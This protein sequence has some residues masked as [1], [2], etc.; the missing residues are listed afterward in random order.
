VGL[1]P[2]GKRD[3]LDWCIGI[4][5]NDLQ[6]ASAILMRNRGLGALT[7]GGNGEQT[8][9]A[10]YQALRSTIAA[11]G[12]LRLG[13]FL[14]G[15]VAWAALLLTELALFPNPLL[16]LL[17]LIVLVAAFEAI[18]S[19][20]FG[21]ER[22]GRYLQVFFEEPAASADMPWTPPA[23]ERAVVRVGGQL[24]GAAGHPLFAPIFALATVMNLS[25]VFLPEPLPAEWIPLTLLH[26]AFLGW[27]LYVDRGVRTQRSHDEKRFREIR[28]ETTKS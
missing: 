21:V 5:A 3:P 19:V 16:S 28:D 11:R 10:E 6:T 24:P 7:L 9:I 18:R 26:G 12:S 17:P 8:A 15:V 14:G 20:H 1:D 22:I 25:A 2:T 27:M 23:W 13:L 4:V